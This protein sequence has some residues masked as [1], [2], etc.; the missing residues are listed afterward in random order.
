MFNLA[1][2]FGYFLILIICSIVAILTA[3][4]KVSWAFL[5]AGAGIQLAS[6]IGLQKNAN[7]TYLNTTPY[8]WTYAIIILLTLAIMVIRKSGQ[9]D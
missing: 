2:M 7:A 6:L 3:K 9:D 5:V 8:W 4:L 1:T